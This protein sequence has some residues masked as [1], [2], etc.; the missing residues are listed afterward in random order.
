MTERKL[1]ADNT[2]DMGMV[3]ALL[4]ENEENILQELIDEKEN[5]IKKL[6]ELQSLVDRELQIEADEDDDNGGSAPKKNES[7]RNAFSFVY[8]LEN[9]AIQS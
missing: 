4:E 9:F 2:P 6:D 8:I 1:T 3:Q 7:E 5:L